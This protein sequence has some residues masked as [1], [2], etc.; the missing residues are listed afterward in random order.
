MERLKR[1]FGYT[2]VNKGQQ[3]Q[4]RQQRQQQK[5]SHIRNVLP[6]VD[7]KSKKKGVRFNNIT[8]KN[9]SVRPTNDE[10]EARKGVSKTTHATGLTHNVALTEENAR[11]FA[12]VMHATKD[13]P[14]NNDKMMNTTIQYIS[15]TVNEPRRTTLINHFKY[16]FGKP[17]ATRKTGVKPN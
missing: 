1:F 13:M 8:N 2:R 7:N 14:N 6:S 12:E 17:N 16:L 10:I 15:K 4:Q 3:G 5:Q 11:V 9:R